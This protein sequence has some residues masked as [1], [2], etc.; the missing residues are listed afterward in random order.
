MM[1]FSTNPPIVMHVDINSCFATIEQQANPALRGRPIAVAAYAEDHGCILAAS[2]E[3][4]RLG[5]KTGMRVR[6]AKMI[7]RHL[8]VLPPDPDKYRFINRA[9]LSLLQNYTSDISVESID[10]MVMNIPIP[11]CHMFFIAQEIKQRIK[12]EIGEWITVSIGIAPNRYLAKVASGLHKPDGLDT[13]TKENITS[14]LAGLKLEDL[15]G[16]KTATANRLRYAG[17]LTPLMMYEAAAPTLQRALHSI[18]GLHWWMRL[19]G[20]EDGSRYTAFGTH[21]DEAPQKSFGQ[22]Y[23]M[24][25][26]YTPQDTPLHQILAHL[27]MKMGRRLRGAGF[28]ACGIGVSTVFTDYSHWHEQHLYKENFYADSDFYSRIKDMLLGAPERPVRILAVHCYK[29]IGAFSSQ[30]SLFEE[31]N[32]KKHLTDALDKVHDKWGDFIVTSGRMLQMH[33]KVLDRIAFGKSGV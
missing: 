24:G 31:D 19:H 28:T 9:L 5:I 11:E 10:E 20:Y 27:V 12:K 6:E 4:K 25:K 7:F 32:R 17:I 16:I 13:I 15:C 22:S 8:V 21:D 26:P 2:V 29:L 33:D 30:E 1:E 3:A 14:I 23:A 18:V